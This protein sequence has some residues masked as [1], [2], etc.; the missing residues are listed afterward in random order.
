MD[1]TMRSRPIVST[2]AFLLAMGGE[3]YL[4]R[5]HLAGLPAEAPIPLLM[6]LFLCGVILIGA[7]CSATPKGWRGKAGCRAAYLL[8]A[9]YLAF[10]IAHFSFFSRL[11]LEGITTE[12]PSY[13]P[14]LAALKLVLVSVG[15]VAATPVASGPDRREYADR[16]WSA[17]RRQQKTWADGA[18]VRGSDADKD[19]A[20]QAAQRLRRELTADELERLKR[21][22]LAEP[23][24]EAEGNSPEAADPSD[25]EAPEEAGKESPGSHEETGKWAGFEGWKGWGC[26]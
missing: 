16:L 24:P 2:A 25:P 8:L 17:A 7:I 10:N 14:A 4:L 19:P 26:C 12:Y 1:N 13:A 22:L 5:G 6:E 23:S 18:A 20:A 11:Y 21:T 15:V 9:G 3:L